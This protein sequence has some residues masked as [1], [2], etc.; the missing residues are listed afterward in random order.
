M[1]GDASV[2]T[3]R[4][5]QQLL[6][7]L[8]LATT[9]VL[10]GLAVA[11]TGA[12]AAQSSSLQALAA[13]DFDG[14]CE[15]WEDTT[16]PDCID[17]GGDNGEEE[18]DCVLT[19]DLCDWSGEDDPELPD[20]LPE[21]IQWPAPPKG[22]YAK[23]RNGRRTAVPPRSAP[24]PVRKMIRAA[25]SLVRKPYK[26]GGGH[27]RFKD[28]GYDC[29]GAVS[30]VLR[31]GG[32]LAYPLDSGGLAKWG[33]RGAGNWVRVYAHKNHAFM[34]VAGLRFDTTPYG[35]SGGKGPRWRATVRPTKGFKLRHPRGL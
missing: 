30:Y 1:Q 10:A 33:A 27:M 24:R 29:S 5:I 9:M 35:A 22:A 8:A 19:P 20:E 13:G 4:S 18:V 12:P 15:D 2:T 17:S 26:W 11:T 23:L 16:D 34:V 31:A 7:I 6:L 25:N 28:R 3:R 21:V 14:E 32:Y